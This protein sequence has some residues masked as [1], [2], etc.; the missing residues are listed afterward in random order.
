MGPVSNRFQKEGHDLIS[1]FVMKR[2]NKYNMVCQLANSTTRSL[3]DMT[4]TELEICTE[5][6][7]GASIGDTLLLQFINLAKA[8][9]ELRRPWMLLRYTDSSKSVATLMR[10]LTT[11][12]VI[13]KERHLLCAFWFISIK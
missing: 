1:F 10:S 12:Q 4:G 5:V 3:W 8:M 13:S 2:D 7:G 11:A 6:N 9:V